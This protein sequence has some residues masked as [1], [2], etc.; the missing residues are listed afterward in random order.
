MPK[1][2]IHSYHR[3]M[4]ENFFSHIDID[5]KNAHVPDGTVARDK[6]WEFCQ[7]YEKRIKEA[8]GLDFQI[9]VK[10]IPAVLRGSGAA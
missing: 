10:T 9:L 4:W 5:P 8:G 7:Q 1:E 6:V 3:F 2:S